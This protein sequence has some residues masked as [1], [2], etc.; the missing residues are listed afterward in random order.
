MNVSQ[1]YRQLLRQGRDLPSPIK[2]KLRYN[3]HRVFK[4]DVEGG[5]NSFEA[6]QRVLKWLSGLPESDKKFLFKHFSNK[7]TSTGSATHG[8]DHSL[9]LKR[10]IHVTQDQKE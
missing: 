8:V 7:V 10:K 2:A 9:F 5:K 1:I 6:A 4:A 3:L